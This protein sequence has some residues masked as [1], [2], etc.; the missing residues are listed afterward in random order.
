MDGIRAPF[1]MEGLIQ[2]AIHQLK[3]RNLRVLAPELGKILSR[4]L[5]THSIPGD[6]LVPVPLHPGRLRRRGYNQALLLAKELGKL[7]G[8]E[9]HDDLL[10]RTKNSP[11]Q[12]EAIS[13]EQRRLN[14]A[15]SFDCRG[16]AAGSKIIL[17]D[18]VT[19]TGSTLSACAAALKRAGASSVWGLTLAREV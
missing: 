19:T 7:Q 17:I 2:D 6:S 11:P 12:V 8:L 10:R 5:Q 15:G 3:Y 18:D 16:D 1:L 14:V 13:L 4:Y 9:V